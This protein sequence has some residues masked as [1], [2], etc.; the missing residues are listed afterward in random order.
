MET[1]TRLVAVQSIAVHSGQLKPTVDKLVP[2]LTLKPDTFTADVS[3][4]AGNNSH[5][6]TSK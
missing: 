5:H 1:T 3:S 4:C 2:P 6:I